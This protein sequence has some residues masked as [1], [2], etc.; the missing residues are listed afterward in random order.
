MVIT[1]F[2]YHPCA[3]F[4]M[5]GSNIFG[6]YQCKDTAVGI[7]GAGITGDRNEVKK[8]RKQ[9]KCFSHLTNIIH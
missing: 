4:K 8:K 3:P 6:R 9:V 7:T 5:G 2:K 1:F